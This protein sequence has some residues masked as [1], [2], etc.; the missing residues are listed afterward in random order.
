MT[1]V[2]LGYH[3]V[4]PTNAAL[5]SALHMTSGWQ[6]ILYIFIHVACREQLNDPGHLP[7]HNQKG[8]ATAEP[9]SAFH[10]ATRASVSGSLV[11][12]TGLNRFTRILDDCP[13]V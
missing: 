2:K 11:R 12:G 13:P 8:R 3:S 7:D 4:A 6:S 1:S 9:Q 5:S 10:P